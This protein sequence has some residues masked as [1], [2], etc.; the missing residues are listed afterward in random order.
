MVEI[1]QVQPPAISIKESSFRTAVTFPLLII[2]VSTAARLIFWASTSWTMEDGMIVAR[3]V[4]NLAT[5]GE[6]TFNV[7]QRVSTATSP[8]FALMAGLLTTVLGN[9]LGA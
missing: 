2:I 6:L 9:P 3:I 4:R 8:I 5:N 1:T 7:G